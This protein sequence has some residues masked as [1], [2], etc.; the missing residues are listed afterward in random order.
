MWSEHRKNP[1]NRPTR[2]EIVSRRPSTTK[3]AEI[4]TGSVLQ[5]SVRVAASGSSCVYD[6][7]ED[8][9]VS[10]ECSM[11]CFEACSDET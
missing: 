10:R 9:N 1:M 2:M 6:K 8:P 5:E 7:V 4:Q 3:F 11:L